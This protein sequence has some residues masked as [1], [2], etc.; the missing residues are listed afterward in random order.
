MNITSY[1]IC[2][3][4]NEVVAVYKILGRLTDIEFKEKGIDEEERELLRNIYN[5]LMPVVYVDV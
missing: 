1:N 3:N 2:L 5:K 4:Y